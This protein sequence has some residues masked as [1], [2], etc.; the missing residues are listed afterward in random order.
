M[1]VKCS[2]PALGVAPCHCIQPLPLHPVIC[3]RLPSP[4]HCTRPL[5]PAICTRPLHSSICT[6][7][8]HPAICTHHCTQPF[9]HGHCT[10]PLHP[11]ICTQPPTP[12]LYTRPFAPGLCTQPFAAS[13]S[14]MHSAICCGRE[15]Y[16]SCCSLLALATVLKTLIVVDMAPPRHGARHRIGVAATLLSPYAVRMQLLCHHAAR[17][18]CGRR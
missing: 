7:P 2:L 11:A 4:G 6:R 8:L 13:A 10:R 5:H 12:N 18:R 15:L 14:C 16:I 3:T 17:P 9:A 1:L